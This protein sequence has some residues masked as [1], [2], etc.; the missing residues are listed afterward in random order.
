MEIKKSE[1]ESIEKMFTSFKNVKKE[2][3]K[4]IIGQDVIVNQLLMTIF[5]GGHCA[6]RCSRPG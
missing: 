5:S 1:I 4:V 2:V 6:N 3:S